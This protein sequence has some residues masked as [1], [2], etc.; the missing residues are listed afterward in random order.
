M[1]SPSKSCLEKKMPDIC[2]VMFPSHFCSKFINMVMEKGHKA[3]ARNLVETVSKLKH[4]ANKN[5]V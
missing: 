2:K 3:V 5:D 4:Q 1:S